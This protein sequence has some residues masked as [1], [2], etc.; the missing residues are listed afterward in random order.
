MCRC[1]NLAT[2]LIDLQQ[3][4]RIH[5]LLKPIMLRRVKSEIQQKL[6][7]KTETKI[8]VGMSGA[9]S[10]NEGGAAALTVLPKS[11]CTGGSLKCS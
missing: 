8:F 11:R 5:T 10:C 6:P 9:S 1:F 7:P 3:L 4:L 2:N